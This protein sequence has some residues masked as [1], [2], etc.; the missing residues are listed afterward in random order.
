L[1]AANGCEFVE[2]GWGK[3]RFL[4]ISDRLV[5]GVVGANLQNRHKNMANM[6][7]KYILHNVK[8]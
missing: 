8:I 4:V 7:K 6:D 2:V 5:R 1:I 3:V